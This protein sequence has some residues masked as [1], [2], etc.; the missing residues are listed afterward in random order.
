MRLAQVLHDPA[1]NNGSEALESVIDAMVPIV[2]TFTFSSNLADYGDLIGSDPRYE[3]FRKEIVD[4]VDTIKK[5][6]QAGVPLLTGSESGF[7]HPTVNGI[8]GSWKFL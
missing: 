3:I 8:T 6:Y 2:P 4:S 1:R 7:S 5:A